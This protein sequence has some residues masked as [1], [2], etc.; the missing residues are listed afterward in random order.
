MVEL[1]ETANDEAVSGQREADAAS[2]QRIANAASDLSTLA[3][4]IVILARESDDA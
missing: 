1:A 3:R 2:A 4:T